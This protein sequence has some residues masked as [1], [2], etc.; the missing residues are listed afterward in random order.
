MNFVQIPTSNAPKK[1][2]GILCSTFFLTPQ[3]K[4]HEE[5][6][7][8][9][10]SFFTKYTFLLIF[11]DNKKNLLKKS[12][13]CKISINSSNMKIILCIEYANTKLW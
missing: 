1:V 2:L 5:S 11:I 6:Y 13:Q 7:I 9:F 4:I 3:I 8:T 10:L 12:Q